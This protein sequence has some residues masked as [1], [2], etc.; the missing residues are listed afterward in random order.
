[1]I[2]SI[3]ILESQIESCEGCGGEID[4]DVPETYSF[5]SLGGVVCCGCEERQLAF[6]NA[7]EVLE[8]VLV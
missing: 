6:E 3:D 4:I 5:T 2:S 7:T 1:M 8:E